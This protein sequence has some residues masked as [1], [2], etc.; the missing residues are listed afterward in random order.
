VHPSRFGFD[1]R[2]VS[3][4][5]ADAVWLFVGLVAA[6]AFVLRLLDAPA[7]ARR[8]AMWLV[9]VTLLQGV[10]GYVQYFTSLP[11]PL[12]VAHMLGASLL[13]V[14]VTGVVVAVTG[15]PWHALVPPAG[16]RGPSR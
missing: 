8:R 10:I 11:A 7:V 2:S 15:T 5:H 12:V 4:L 6:L 3:W 14:A 1:P 9:V 16:T 13:T